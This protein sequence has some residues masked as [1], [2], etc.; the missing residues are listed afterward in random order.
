MNVMRF[1][2][3][4]AAAALLA[5]V[6][7]AAQERAA[8]TAAV[9]PFVAVDAPVVALR[10]VRLVDGTGTPARDDQTVIVRG[11][12]I[13]EVGPTA[14]TPVPRNAHVMN[15]PGHTVIPGLVGLHEHTYFGGVRRTAPMN[16]SAY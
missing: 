5:A 3:T 14:S 10:H 8:P 7:L 2:P 12:R 1:R 13:E 4:A 11:T 9:R 15:L 16:A 6:P